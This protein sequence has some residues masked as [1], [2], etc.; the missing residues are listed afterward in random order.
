MDNSISS[1]GKY[2]CV[3]K[4]KFDIFNDSSEESDSDNDKHKEQKYEPPKNIINVVDD[5]KIDKSDKNCKPKI[6]ENMQ[7]EWTPINKKQYKNDKYHLKKE[8]TQNL[9]PEETGELIKLSE[10]YQLWVHASSNQSWMLH[11]CKNILD[12]KNVSDMWRFI[13]NLRKLNFK[14][15]DF[16]LMRNGIYPLW[17]AAENKNGSKYSIRTDI[18]T[19]FEIASILILNLCCDSI[20][21]NDKTYVNG[22][23]MCVKNNWLLIKIMCK[24]KTDKIKEHLETNLLHKFNN[25]SI[26]H[27]IIE[28][29]YD[30]IKS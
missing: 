28:P 4:N 30:D 11:D 10:T 18:N 27:Q 19:G 1:N 14:T 5:E 26:W 9:T 21:P 24:E 16:I 13:N 17:E 23:N 6:D 8:I 7:N 2:I 12:I 3:K 15:N 29:E 22:I 20:S 25:L